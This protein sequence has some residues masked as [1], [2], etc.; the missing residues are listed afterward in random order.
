MAKITSKVATT[1]T[2]A[3]IGVIVLGQG[4]SIASPRSADGTPNIQVESEFKCKQV[5]KYEQLPDLPQYSGQSEFVHGIITP[6]A[7][8]GASVT[9][10]IAVRENKDMVVYWWREALKSYKWTPC[11]DQTANA[12]IANKDKNYVQVVVTNSGR[13]NYPTSI[14]I[15][16]RMSR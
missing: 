2:A 10:E 16:Y 5:K 12:V 7:R 3:L 13:V 9:Y 6:E 1:I 14:M 11:G 4:A 15:S 8:G